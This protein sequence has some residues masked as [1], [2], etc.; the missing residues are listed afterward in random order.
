VGRGQ[1]GVPNERQVGE[2]RGKAASKKEL[3]GGTL[4]T[5]TLSY[6]G[7]VLYV[8][9]EYPTWFSGVIT[10]F[11]GLVLLAMV[12]SLASVK[13][14]QVLSP[15]HTFSEV[16]FEVNVIAG[17]DLGQATFVTGAYVGTGV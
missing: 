13:R 3:A 11:S 1:A 16:R 2:F 5:V 8:W 7:I 10:A 15:Y 17:S 6:S 4:L 9:A 12:F 14:R